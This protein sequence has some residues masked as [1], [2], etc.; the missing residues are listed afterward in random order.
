MVSLKPSNSH[1]A[2]IS[3]TTRTS[4]KVLKFSADLPQMIVA[5]VEY[6]NPAGQSIVDQ[7]MGKL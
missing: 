6:V 5:L 1:F 3:R 4:R 2:L 7:R